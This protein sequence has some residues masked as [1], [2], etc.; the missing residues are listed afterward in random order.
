VVPTFNE[1]RNLPYVLPRIPRW[2]HEVI[3]VDG[4]STDDTL[5][6]ARE[7]WPT[8]RTVLQ[9]GRGKGDAL[10][11]GFR[12]ATGDII[13]CLDA[14]GSADPAEIS[15][16][17]G[18]LMSGIDF[19]KG[20]RFL[21]GGG[22]ADIS[23][24]RRLGNGGLRFAARLAFGGR[25]SDLCYGYN[26]F[27]ADVLPNIEPDVDGFEIE[28]LMN[29]RAL[30]S[31]LTVCEVPSFESLRVHGSSNLRPIA[32]GLR[33]LRTIMRERVRRAPQPALIAG[34]GPADLA[35]NG[36]AQPAIELSA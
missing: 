2:V 35:V 7:V 18:V 16:F 3:V 34:S 11:C 24:C 28:T 22:T 9:D 5:E 29:I 10:C 20:S 21:Q 17:V 36:Q 14:D 25:F 12:A 13:V 27:W 33:V 4:H 31:R 1:A 32:D 6:V 19:A 26:A 8:V 23:L 30:R 15:A